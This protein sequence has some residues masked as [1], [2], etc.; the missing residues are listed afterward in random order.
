MNVKKIALELGIHPSKKMGQN[1]L[2]HD[3]TSK[4]I[5]DWADIPAGANVVEIGPG[6]GA[7][8]FQLVDRGYPVYLI[9]KDRKLHAYLLEKL[10]K[11]VSLAQADVLDFSFDEVFKNETFFLISN[12]PYSISSP[13]LEKALSMIDRI[14][15]MVFLFQEEV[16]D[17]IGAEAGS[18]DYGRL[19]IWVQ[20]QCDVERGPRISKEN[21]YPKPDVESRLVKLTPSQ[22]PLVPKKEQEKFL[23]WVAKIFQQRRKTLRKNLKDN[24]FDPEVI[25]R[26]FEENKIIE[27][28]RA[29]EL[30]IESLYCLFKSL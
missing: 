12:A 22:N 16:V 6:L 1:F 18:K 7:L 27:T 5:L 3:N 9:E 11:S 29:E 19:T 4:K 15:G 10:P 8:S 21:F 13:I 20:C 28:A 25:Q 17:R 23:Q 30:S 24:D 26:A 2:L 14:S